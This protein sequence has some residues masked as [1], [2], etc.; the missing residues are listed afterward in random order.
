MSAIVFLP[1]TRRRDDEQRA[2]FAQ[3]R[4]AASVLGARGHAGRE[5]RFFTRY[6][7]DHVREEPQACM[8]QGAAFA[9]FTMISGFDR[10]IT[11]AIANGTMV[12][13]A[14]VHPGYLRES[15][16]MPLPSFVTSS[17]PR[18]SRQLLYHCHSGYP[19]Q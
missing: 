3:V 1:P 11:Q 14:A 15:A 17:A 19:R 18:M 12:G 8:V 16:P 10:D 9:D 4:L 7:L 6:D 13:G 5:R 2:P